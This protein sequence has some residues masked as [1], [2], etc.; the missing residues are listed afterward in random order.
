MAPVRDAD[1]NLV[2]RAVPYNATNPATPLEGAAVPGPIRTADGDPVGRTALYQV[3]GG[4]A[5]PITDLGGTAAEQVTAQP[6][7][8]ATPSGDNVELTLTTDQAGAV[9][10]LDG[11]GLIKLSQMPISGLNY[12]G[13]WDASTNTPTLADG[14]GTAGDMYRVHVAGAQDL[15]SGS[16]TFDVG[17]LVVY[18]GA[19]WQK[20][21]AATGVISVNGQTGAVSLTYSDLP[22][23]PITRQSGTIALILDNE[24]L[25]WPSDI[26]TGKIRLY[27][28]TPGSNNTFYGLGI[29]NQTFIYQVDGSGSVH[30]FQSVD[31]S[32]NAVE[33]FDISTDGGVVSYLDLHM[34]EKKIINLGNPTSPRDATNKQ[35]VDQ[36][37]AG[38]G[39]GHLT[40]E[41]H[42]DG[43]DVSPTPDSATVQLI[44]ATAATA[45]VVVNLPDSTDNTP[46][47]KVFTIKRLD[48]SANGITIDGGEGNIDGAAS[49][50][51]A[52]QW[53]W[54]TIVFDGTNWNI[55]AS[56]GS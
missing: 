4:V 53:S 43:N 23:I 38:V 47:G 28:S 46:A 10:L 27:N 52:D 32:D 3:S 34:S 11:T 1:G 56:G 30:K 24:D 51:L 8:V 15:G 6:P 25:I 31:D 5:T 17:D 55:I 39:G 42:T 29:A 13:N 44:D 48:G 41:T 26:A 7:I 45:T 37:V 49:Q 18:E 36:A 12:H 19:I 50:G 54:K 40:V 20:F 9:P 16:I 35:Y 33:L 2:G 22:G 21:A 14:A